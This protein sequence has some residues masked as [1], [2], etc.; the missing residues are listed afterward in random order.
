MNRKWVLVL[1]II[2]LFLA[3]LACMSRIEAENQAKTE[4]VKTMAATSI[5]LSKTQTQ[6]VKVTPTITPQPSP[7]CELD[8]MGFCMISDALDVNNVFGRTPQPTFTEQDVI[9]WAKVKG[10]NSMPLYNEP[11]ERANEVGRIFPV[12]W[13]PVNESVSGWI[14]S[15]GVDGHYF[16]THLTCWLE[17][18][19]ISNDRTT[20]EA[21][22]HN[23]EH[24]KD[25]DLTHAHCQSVN[26]NLI[27]WI[28][29]GVDI[30]KSVFDEERNVYLVTLEMLW[31]KNQGIKKRE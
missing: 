26:G 29:P 13:W 21:I 19:D 1:P 7:T 16:G 20:V 4:V 6:Q 28:D 11:G 17:E 31:V 30:V 18:A 2:S 8:V 24:P 5:A 14:Q 22:E 15:Y 9:F 10:D 3:S 25:D 12:E 23:W 27:A